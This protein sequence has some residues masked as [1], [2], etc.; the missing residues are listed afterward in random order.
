[1][2]RRIFLKSAVAA[3]AL[4]LT[5][6][7]G[8]VAREARKAAQRGPGPMMPNTPGITVLA[9]PGQSEQELVGKLLAHAKSIGATYCDVRLVRYLSQ[10]VSVR[11]AIV[12]GISD[13]ESYGIGVRVIKNGTWGFASSN[14]V[15]EKAGKN[16]IQ[17]AVDMA[18]ANAKLQSQPL[19]LAP[20]DAVTT[21]WKTP[22]KKNPFEVSFKDRAQFLLDMHALAAATNIGGNKLFVN[23][24]L[25]CV[26]EEKYFASTDGSSIWQEITRM[27]PS[28]WLTVSDAATGKFASRSLFVLPQGRGFEYVE[29]YPYKDEIKQAA[30]DAHEKLNAASVEPGKYDLILHPTHLWLTIHE[31]IG[32][33]TELDRALGYEANFAGTSFVTVDKLNDFKY[34]TKLVTVVADRTQEGGLATVGFD[35]DG[36]PSQEYPLIDKGE[37]V[38]Y[39]TTREQARMIKEPRSRGQSYAQGWWSVPFQRMPNVSLKPNEQPYSLAQMIA[40]TDRGILIKGN[41]SYSIDQQRYN[42][43]FTGQVAYEV[44]SGKITRMLRDVAYQATTPKFWKS[45]DYLCDK[46]EYML[47]GAM[48]DGKGEPMQA[49]PVSHGCPP[50]RFSDVNVINTRTQSANT[51]SNMID[52]D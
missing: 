12:T 7:D 15:T 17:E 23:S 52:Y 19:D 20:V 8:L 39:Q 37:F 16:L 24:N 43:Q 18:T 36:V 14:A 29:N 47:G 32:H 9:K 5:G 50:A 22:I 41:S 48:Y 10:S 6:L 1:M 2:D 28:S 31:S 25:N 49:N 44:K 35:D 3:G 21:E 33:P 11:E 46:S 13:S 26:R 38:G 42:F 40:D 30:E 45:L 51:R 27:D 4:S 34:G